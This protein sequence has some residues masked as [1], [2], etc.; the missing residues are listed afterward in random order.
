[1]SSTHRILLAFCLVSTCHAIGRTQS[2]AV[3]GILLCEDGPAKDVLIKLYDHDTVSPDELMDSAKTDANG[4]FRLS[5]TADEIS[6]IDPK[7]NIYHDCD[8]GIKP[9]QRRITIFIPSKYVSNTK[10]PSETFNLGRLQLAGKYDGE[11]RDC[12]H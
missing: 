10:Q 4:H 5:G 8:D 12:L 6:G 2:T 7:I 11:S 1:M 3:E 9:C